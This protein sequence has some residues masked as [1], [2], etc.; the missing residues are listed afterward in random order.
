[1]TSRWPVRSNAAASA[2]VV[3]AVVVVAVVVV[4]GVVS[5][6]VDAQLDED[7]VVADE[8]VAAQVLVRKAQADALVVVARHGPLPVPGR[9]QHLH[10]HGTRRQ[11]VQSEPPKQRKTKKKNGKKFQARSNDFIEIHKRKRTRYH[12]EEERARK[13]KHA[14]DL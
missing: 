3:V 9:A 2:V 5:V 7:G 6:E 1:M 8:T 12:E 14:S 10:R 11:Q 4:V 13:K